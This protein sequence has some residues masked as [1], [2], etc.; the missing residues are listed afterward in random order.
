MAI[1]EGYKFGWGLCLHLHACWH[2]PSLSAESDDWASVP[3]RAW[4]QRKFSDVSK[5]TRS[6][7]QRYH[8]SPLQKRNFPSIDFVKMQRARPKRI[9]ADCFT[10]SFQIFL[11]RGLFQNAVPRKR[12]CQRRADIWLGICTFGPHFRPTSATLCM[13]HRLSLPGTNV[14]TISARTGLSRGKAKGDAIQ[15]RSCGATR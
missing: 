5:P 13:K 10:Q 14:A 8:V 4:A 7:S 1:R 11:S 12:M 15:T 6:P 9:N 2:L 3:S